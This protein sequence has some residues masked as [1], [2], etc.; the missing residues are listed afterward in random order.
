MKQGASNYEQEL[1]VFFLNFLPYI[2]QQDNKNI[3]SRKSI[4][5]FSVKIDGF[6]K[7]KQFH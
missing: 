1:T 2:V 6:Y 7:M 4:P 5:I 3:S